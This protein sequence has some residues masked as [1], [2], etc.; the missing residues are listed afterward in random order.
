MQLVAAVLHHVQARA[1]MERDRD[2]VAQAGGVAAVGAEDLTDRGRLV[3]P[4]AG[5]TFSSFR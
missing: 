5:G 2:R 4:D 1:R 3:L